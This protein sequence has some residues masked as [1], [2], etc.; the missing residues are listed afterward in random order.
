VS[1]VEEIQAAIEKLTALRDRASLAPWNAWKQGRPGDRMTHG[2]EDAR[3]DDLA[4]SLSAADAEL[5][6]A[7]H[8]TIDA[9][10]AILRDDYETCLKNRWIPDRF[11]LSI[12]RAINGATK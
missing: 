12:A 1:A 7:L 6:E 2:L 5:I 11:I 3:G 9:Q 10:L 8:R 4:K